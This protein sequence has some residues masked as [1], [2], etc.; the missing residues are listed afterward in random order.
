M[1]PRYR[2]IPCIVN[3][4]KITIPRPPAIFLSIDTVCISQPLTSIKRK[5]SLMF[6]SKKQK[7][8]HIQSPA[9]LIPLFSGGA[10]AN[11]PR[12]C[13]CSAK[14]TS[15]KANRNRV[16]QPGAEKKNLPRATGRFHPVQA[17][18]TPCRTAI[19][20]HTAIHRAR[21][22]VPVLRSSAIARV[23]M[24]G[25]D[26]HLAAT[27]DDKQFCDGLGRGWRSRRADG[28]RRPAA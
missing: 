26:T 20:D 19:L 22:V 17:I 21:K 16:P 8:A 2:M 28:A 4:Q 14:G 13:I 10:G 11:T 27:T 5:P 23:K 24:G 7:I 15:V 3:V 18:R 25:S 6:R 1:L 9:H 12:T